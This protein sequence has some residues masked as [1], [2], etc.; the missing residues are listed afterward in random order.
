M[1]DQ[2]PVDLIHLSDGQDVS[3]ILRAV[4]P[5][6]SRHGPVPAECL[7]TADFVTAR[8]E[9]HIWPDLLDEWEEALARLGADAQAAAAADRAQAPVA[10]AFAAVAR[11]RAA[12]ARAVRGAAA[13]VRT[14]AA[15]AAAAVVPGQGVR[16]RRHAQALPL[17]GADLGRAASAA[18][19]A[20]SIAAA[21][22]P[23]A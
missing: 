2:A 1:E 5:P 19:A 3:L 4:G 18:G 9:T 14:R 21:L 16:R 11:R 20:A 10:A 7:V 13:A 17:G 22:A 12:A 6:P 8:L 23:G 15:R